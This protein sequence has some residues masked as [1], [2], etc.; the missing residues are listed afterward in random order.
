MAKEDV[1]LAARRLAARAHEG[2]TRFGTNAPYITH[3]AAVVHILEQTGERRP[4]ML[5]AAWLHDVVEDSD[6]ALSMIA[7]TVGPEVACLV[8]LLTKR[9][10]IPEDEYY[11][12]IFA[13][14]ESTELKLADRIHNLREVVVKG[15][16][17]AWA[18]AHETLCVFK[19]AHHCPTLIALLLEEVW[20]LLDRI[21]GRSARRPEAAKAPRPSMAQAFF[22]KALASHGGAQ[23]AWLTAV[24]EVTVRACERRGWYA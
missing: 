8:D 1:I 22:L 17:A 21:G 13:S 4:H 20:N 14:A 18:Y 23:V 24:S 7:A 5:A 6:V 11:Q 2:Q 10:G 19:A 12:R 3:P 15:P 16:E 9:P